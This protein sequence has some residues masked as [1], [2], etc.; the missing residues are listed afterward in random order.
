MKRCG[1]HIEKERGFC[2]LKPN[3]KGE[4]SKFPAK[5]G[6]H[7]PK[8]RVVIP[9]RVDYQPQYDK[10]TVICEGSTVG[11]NG[12][13]AKLKISDLVYIQ[14]HWYTPPSG[15]TDGD[16]WNSGEGQFECPKCEKLNRLYERPEV[17]K[18]RQYFKEVRNTYER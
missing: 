9:A 11:D 15:C 13:G 12:C 4:C 14:T 1:K 5:Q 17:E 3:H 18:L 6:V 16:Y 8:K 2:A 10:A 7:V